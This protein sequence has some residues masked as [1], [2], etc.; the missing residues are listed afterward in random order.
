MRN[1]YGG[2]REEEDGALELPY[3]TKPKWARFIKSMVEE[4]P[5][6]AL[7]EEFYSQ[8]GWL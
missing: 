6:Q 3:I 4:H 7:L 5:C 2:E 1:G 8:A